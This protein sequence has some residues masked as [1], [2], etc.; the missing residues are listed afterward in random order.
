MKHWIVIFQVDL[1]ADQEVYIKVKAN[2]EQ[3]AIAAAE[4]KAK[5]MDFFHIKFISAKECE[6]K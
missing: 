6:S 4:K 2:T 1:C 5:D 3:K